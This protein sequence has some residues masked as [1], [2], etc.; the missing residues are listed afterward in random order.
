VGYDETVFVV[1]GPPDRL[2]LCTGGNVCYR[3]SWGRVMAEITQLEIVQMELMVLAGNTFMVFELG[4]LVGG[5]MGL[6]MEVDYS[7]VVN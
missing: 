7:A 6:R 3:K 2:Y 5:V 1:W 4:A